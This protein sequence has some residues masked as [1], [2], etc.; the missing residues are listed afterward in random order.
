MALQAADSNLGRITLARQTV[1][2]E[3]PD[4]FDRNTMRILSSALAANKDTEVSNE[5][6]ADRMISDLA[7]VGFTSGGDL[8]YELSMK[9]FPALIEAAICGTYAAVIDFTGTISVVAATQTISDPGLAGTMFAD[10]VPNQRFYLV[11]PLNTGWHKIV[12]VTDADTVVVATPVAELSDESDSGTAKGQMLRNPSDPANIIKRPHAIEQYFSDRDVSQLYYD[13]YVGTWNL[14]TAAQAIVNG[15]F[16]LM[17]TQMTAQTGQAAG[18]IAAPTSTPVINAT[19]NVGAILINGVK[20]ACL[21]QSINMALTNNLRN[22]PAVGS[23]YACGIGYGR[24]GITGTATLYF[25]DLTFYNLFLAHADVELAW[26][27]ADA[28]GNGMHITLPRTK[29]ATDTPNLPGIDQDV[30]EAIDY[31]AIAY[32]DGL[33][34]QYQIQVDVAEAA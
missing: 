14:D 18:T 15:I 25:Q 33:G 26:G 27:Y 32:D 19:S 23:K 29:F 5:L 2:G 13:Q 9:T 3:L 11:T 28:L 22:Q 16:G 8:G 12:T 31:Q 30:M 21:V 20:Q 6:R 34:N 17:G 1:L 10:A 7:E 4:P 24:Q